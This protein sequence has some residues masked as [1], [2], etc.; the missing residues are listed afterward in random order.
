MFLS[1]F[2][3]HSCLLLSQSFYLS[4]NLASPTS[5]NPFY[6]PSFTTA[7]L[8]G[9]PL[10]HCGPTTSL[11]IQGQACLPGLLP[12]L[13]NIAPSYCQLA[14]TMAAEEGLLVFTFHELEPNWSCFTV[15]LLGA[16]NKDMSPIPPVLRHILSLKLLLWGLLGKNH[17]GHLYT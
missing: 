14:A 2:H 10:Y 3:W 13:E 15:Q 11:L 17:S 4:S 9:L 8:S 1:M 5:H 12:Q 6:M 16:C 7:C